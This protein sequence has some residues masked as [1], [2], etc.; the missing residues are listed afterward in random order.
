MKSISV[1][2]AFGE[3]CAV[4]GGDSEFPE[5]LVYLKNE[6]GNELMLTAVTDNTVLGEDSEVY[7]LRTAVYGDPCA[8][9]YS[10]CF[11]MTHEQLNSPYAMWE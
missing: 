6:A 11:V 8:E 9:D 2:T 10:D 1:D 5:I 3:L 4:V 7:G